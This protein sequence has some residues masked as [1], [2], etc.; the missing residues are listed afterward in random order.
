MKPTEEVV[1]LSE[2][3]FSVDD[4]RSGLTAIDRKRFDKY[5]LLSYMG[6]GY[7]VTARGRYAGVVRLGGT[8]YWL[9]PGFPIDVLLRLMLLHLGLQAEDLRAPA[10][11]RAAA[12]RTDDGLMPLL[13]CRLVRE[14]ERLAAGH[15]V[16]VYTSRTERTSTLRGRP[17]W[18][19]AAM[20]PPDGRLLCRYDE[21][22]SD[23]LPNQLLLAGLLEAR[24]YL[25][26]V[27]GWRRRL[28]SQIHVW[29]SLASYRATSW[30]EFDLVLLTLNRLGAPYRGPLVLARTLLFGYDVA[31]PESHLTSPVVDLAALFETLVTRL[32]SLALTD[33]GV[34]A[35]PQQQNR[36]A[37]RDASGRTYIRPRPDLVLTRGKTV[38]AVLDAKYKPRYVSFGPALSA[39]N[40]VAAADIYQMFFYSRRTVSGA[41]SVPVFI[42]AP[43]LPGGISPVTSARSITWR[44][45]GPFSA[46]R[47][48]GIDLASA[49][50]AVSDRDVE[51]ARRLLPEVVEIVDVVA[52]TSSS[53]RSEGVVSTH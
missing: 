49:V 17:L 38:L 51:A 23:N 39:K 3:V 30:H 16:Q 29:S 19:R 44:G 25:A 5:L 37:I 36:H 13:A 45:D 8:R 15:V 35:R 26:H 40:R 1:D 48:L 6:G 12:L 21:K 20:H 22:T 53:L 28:R 41:E 47:I 43:A 32:T 11:V 33:T 46:L 9:P 4:P 18:H 27:S 42:V 10:A 34:V 31:D 14:A 2:G 50:H 52:R 7:L 24:R